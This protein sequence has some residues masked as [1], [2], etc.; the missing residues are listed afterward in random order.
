MILSCDLKHSYRLYISIRH[1]IR[2]K[3]NNCLS[4]ILSRALFISRVLLSII[5]SR[6]VY[7]KFKIQFQP[8]K[9][10]AENSIIH[11]CLFYEFKFETKIIGIAQNL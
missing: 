7:F 9:T 3:S 11:P 2:Q 5:E 4:V 10:T 6:T 1:F 8:L